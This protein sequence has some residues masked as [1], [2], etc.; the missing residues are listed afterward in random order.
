MIVSVLFVCRPLDVLK[1]LLMSSSS[2]LSAFAYYEVAITM[3]SGT[4]VSDK[5]S[6]HGPV[7]QRTLQL[8]LVYNTRD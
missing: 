7:S 4:K 8:V 6:L 3:I 1:S 5:G 2:W